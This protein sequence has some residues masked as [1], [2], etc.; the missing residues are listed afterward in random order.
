M[1]EKSLAAAYAVK[2]KA[3]KMAEGGPV[4]KSVFSDLED[5]VRQ[6]FGDKPRPE[7]EETQEEKYAKIRE[8]NKANM[9]YAR[10]GIVHDPESVVKQ[11][12]EAMHSKKRHMADGGLVETY[13][14]DD[15]VEFDPLDD[16]KPDHF[17]GGGPVLPG[18]QAAQDSLRKAFKFADGGEVE[19]QEDDEK[20]LS[21]EEKKK[22][23]MKRI[24]LAMDDS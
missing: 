21:P 3:K 10:G 19:S 24:M 6:S 12:R 1:S 8:Q 4:E 17:D 23:R 7:H 22:E 13:P 9:G 18:A 11:I 5:K 20:E 2:R 16:E 15:L 14:D